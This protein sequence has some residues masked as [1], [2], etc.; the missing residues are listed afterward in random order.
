MTELLK[1]AGYN[2]FAVGKWHLGAHDKF[3]PIHRGFDHYFGVPYSLDMGCTDQLGGVHPSMAPC[4]QHL[5]D[6]PGVPMMRNDT[7]VEQP[8]TFE[9]VTDQYVREFETRIDQLAKE[10]K[11]IFAYVPFS[12][13]HVPIGYNGRYKKHSNSSYHNALFEM[14]QSVGA[15][16]NV[17]ERH[18]MMENTLV[19]IMG[20]NGPWEQECQF[21][22]K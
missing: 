20:D 18:N 21:A 19:W 10:D 8:I 6:K 22:G 1:D 9:T 14:D 11:P 3:L 5:Y 12:H 17:L 15:M 16:M 2:T 4:N 7:V 13:L